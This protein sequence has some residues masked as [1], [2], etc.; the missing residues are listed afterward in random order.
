MEREQDVQVDLALTFLGGMTKLPAPREAPAACINSTLSE[1]HGVGSVVLG[2]RETSVQ[3]LSE[4]GG[5][6][7]LKILQEGAIDGLLQV[8]T[9]LGHF[10]L[11]K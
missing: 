5:L 7:S 11:L 1:L 8:H 10:L 6:V 4:Q 2:K 3:V 9:L